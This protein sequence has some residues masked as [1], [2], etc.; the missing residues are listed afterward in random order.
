MSC[1]VS[2]GGLDSRI[3]EVKLLEAE[4]VLAQDLLG[5]GANASRDCRGA[6]PPSGLLL[7]GRADG[8]G[9]EGGGARMSG[10]WGAGPAKGL[11]CASCR[12]TGNI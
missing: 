4:L 5:I 10:F 8:G 9:P 7:G 2:V 1:D 12:P 3:C 6:S 11:N